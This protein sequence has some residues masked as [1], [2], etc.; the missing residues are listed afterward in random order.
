MCISKEEIL[1]CFPIIAPYKYIDEIIFV[2][3][4]S[5]VATY[6]FKLDEYFYKGHFPGYPITPGAIL[7]ES[8]VQI[9][10]LAFGMYLV[11]NGH[12]ELSDIS[13][14]LAGGHTSLLPDA[15]SPIHVGD[16]DIPSG[17]S[18]NF[19]SYRFFLVSSDLVFKHIILPEE[20]IIVSAE[21]I[22]FKMNKLKVKIKVETTTGRLACEGI[23]SGFVVKLSS[24]KEEL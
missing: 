8:S 10:L 23:V 6:R 5:I 24:W 20:K 18:S 17:I 14:E 1:R 19:F 3:P 2:S 7:M 16:L 12:V 22:F 11:G 13:S 21:K 9:G 15:V 4:G